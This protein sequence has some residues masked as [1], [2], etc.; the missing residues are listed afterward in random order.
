[1]DTSCGM[2]QGRPFGGIGILW[3]KSIGSCIHT[4]K[5]NDSSSVVVAKKP[6]SIRLA[7]LNT[8]ATQSHARYVCEQMKNDHATYH[9][10]RGTNRMI[11]QK[12]NKIQFATIM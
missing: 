7:I 10:I 5:Y 1:M 6:E 11:C 9:V 2:T 12:Y 3:R 8:L 4:H